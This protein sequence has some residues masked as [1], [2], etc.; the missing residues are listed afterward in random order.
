MDRRR[1]PAA[2]LPARLLHRAGGH[3]RLRPRRRHGRGARPT[4]SASAARSTSSPTLGEGTTWRLTHP[5]DAGDHPGADRRVRRRALRDPAGR[6]ARAGLPRRPG[7]R[8]DRVRLRRAGLPA[9]RQAAAAGPPRPTPRP[10]TPARDDRTSTSRCCRP[11][12]AASAWSSTASSTPRRS[13]SSRSTARFKAIG[14]LRRRHDPRRRQGRADP[15]RAGAGPPLAPRPLDRAEPRGRRAPAADAGRA[16]TVDRLLIAGVGE[17][18]VA[19]PLDTVTRLEEF[20][21][22]PVERVGSREVVQYRGADPAAAPAGAP[23]RRVRPRTTG[24][25]RA[26]GRLHRAAA[27]ASRWSSTRSSTSSRTTPT[28]AATSTTTACSAPP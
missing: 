10:S 12:A 5:A 22:R 20:P 19:I 3:Q 15:R 6:R 25:D 1:D 11:T 17:R 23:A 7:R 18:R 4:S 26:G 13:S 14:V 16:A 21:R 24:D 28:S 2:G 8:Q 27:A 9:A